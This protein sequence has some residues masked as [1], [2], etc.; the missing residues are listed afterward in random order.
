M[1]I[2]LYAAGSAEA[3]GTCLCLQHSACCSRTCA[4]PQGHHTGRV[5]A[6]PQHLH[7]P[8]VH[9]E[10][11]DRCALESRQALRQGI[12]LL[13]GLDESLDQT[14]A[15]SLASSANHSCSPAARRCACAPTFHVSAPTVAASACDYI[16]PCCIAPGVEIGVNPETLKT[17]GVTCADPNCASPANPEAAQLYQTSRQEYN[18]RVRRISQRSAEC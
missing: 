10:L 7:D 4:A 17:P 3:A 6:L 2:L 15:Y 5:V 8:A 12:T 9:P 13:S 11:V 16:L 18:R 1:H 14:L